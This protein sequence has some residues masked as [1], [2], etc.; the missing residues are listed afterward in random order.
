MTAQHRMHATEVEAENTG[1][2]TLFNKSVIIYINI[3]F[4]G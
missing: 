3:C 4:D 2:S 1:F